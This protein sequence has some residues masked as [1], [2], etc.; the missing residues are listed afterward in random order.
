M[1]QLGMSISTVDKEL[2]F[3]DPKEEATYWKQV[4]EDLERKL[5]EARDELDEFQEGSRELEAELETQ[6]EQAEARQRE[7][8]SAKTR[9]ETENESLKARL[10]ASQ[11][12]SY[13]T[14]SA[15][16][17]EVAQL[18]AVREEV[19]KYVRELEQANDD[20]ERA[21]RATVCSLEDFEQKLNQAIERNAI[22]ENELDEKE[23]LQE[24]V[25]RLKDE[26]RDLR[27]EL[28]VK[29]KER[30]KPGDGLEFSKDK[31]SNKENKEPL[32]I[33]GSPLKP[34]TTSQTSDFHATTA[35]IGTS[36]LHT[37]Y[38]TSPL[39]PSARISALNIV[40]DLLRKVGAL[41]S[42]L[43]S[44]RNFVKDQ[45]RNPRGSTGSNSPSDSPR[46]SRIPKSSYQNPGMQG[47][48][49]VQV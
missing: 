16:Q 30:K 22:L 20:L 9:L 19:Q 36:P 31:E 25:Q 39:T 28:A 4:A 8:L 26:A 11:N 12:E 27:Q 33:E 47:L 35:S 37:G 38:G 46:P 3:A 14:I 17:D 40:G 45:P 6:L 5:Q 18:K 32:K 1:R 48:V 2:E 44:C 43:A 13:L 23:T 41:E 34:E 15:L 24:S 10:D 49:K 21:K 42:K 29:E 7:L